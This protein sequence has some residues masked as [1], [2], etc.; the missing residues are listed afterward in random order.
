L[1]DIFSKYAS[2][3]P[4]KSKQPPDVLAGLLERLQKMGRNPKLLCS[5][6]EGSLNSND[7]MNY[8]E[9]ENIELGKNR[10]YPFFAERFKRSYTDLLCC[11]KG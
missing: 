3:I 9:K 10:A 5:D 6:E 1:I 4:T 7:I 2:A 11:S 8:L